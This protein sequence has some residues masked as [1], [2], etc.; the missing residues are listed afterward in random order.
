MEENISLLLAVNTTL[1]S[2]PLYI[3]NGTEAMDKLEGCRNAIRSVI[4]RL[5]ETEKEVKNG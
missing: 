4:E 1:E 3:I 2:I 5:R